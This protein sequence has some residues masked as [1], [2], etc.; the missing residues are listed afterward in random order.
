MKDP[1][2]WLEFMDFIEIT[3]T[4]GTLKSYVLTIVELIFDI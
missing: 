4:S 1:I 2:V 3:K